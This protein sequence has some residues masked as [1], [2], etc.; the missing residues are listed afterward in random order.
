MSPRARWMSHPK[1]HPGSSLHHRPWRRLS[2]T[3][4]TKRKRRRR[5]KGNMNKSLLSVTPPT[6][7]FLNPINRMTTIDRPPILLFLLSPC[8]SS[9]PFTGNSRTLTFYLAAT[10]CSFVQIISLQSLCDFS[11]SP[12]SSTSQLVLTTGLTTCWQMLTR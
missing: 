9:R 2:W 12:L 6:P 7:T 5:R 3:A 10:S 8:S 11:R 1:G 4:T